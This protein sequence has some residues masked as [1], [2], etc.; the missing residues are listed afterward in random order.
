MDRPGRGRTGNFTKTDQQYTS[1]DVI[2]TKSDNCH[3][4]NILLSCFCV[5]FG[6]VKKLKN[7]QKKL[8][9]KS[10]RRKATKV[11]GERTCVENVMKRVEKKFV[12]KILLVKKKK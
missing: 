11:K 4:V 3:L 12:G 6:C 2:K 9:M 1:V 8:F 7:T 10:A 5:F